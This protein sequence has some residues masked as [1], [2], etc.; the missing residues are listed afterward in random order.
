[1]RYQVFLHPNIT[2][3]KDFSFTGFVNI[4]VRANSDS[5]SDILLHS[6]DLEIEKVK[7][8]E[9]LQGTEGDILSEADKLGKDV[10]Y[11]DYLA[12][13]KK[14]EMLMIRLQDGDTL[15]SKLL[16][17]IHI[18]FKGKLS[19]GL[20]GFYLSSYKKKGEKEPT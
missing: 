2:N 16:Y 17:V 1:M 5:V 19:T 6:K 18:K 11:K 7:L 10:A 13:N 14:N 3:K 9:I 20:E 12:D 8:Y 15:D 4:L